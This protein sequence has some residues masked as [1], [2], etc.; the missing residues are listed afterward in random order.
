M[1]DHCNP[2]GI[3]GERLQWNYLELDC[4]GQQDQYTIGTTTT[5]RMTS[6]N[7]DQHHRIMP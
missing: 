3:F 6:N 7:N 2:L 1:E 5:P 4:H